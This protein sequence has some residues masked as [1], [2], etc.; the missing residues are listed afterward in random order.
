MRSFISM[1]SAAF[2]LLAATNGRGYN[3]KSNGST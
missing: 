1:T 2:V 3:Q